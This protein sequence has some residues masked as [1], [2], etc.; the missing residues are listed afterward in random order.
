MSLL[1]LCLKWEGVAEVALDAVGVEVWGEDEAVGVEE[2]EEVVAFGGGD[3]AGER[4]FEGE[5]VG[6]CFVY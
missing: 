6:E 1:C 4:R 3:G 2:G 5:E